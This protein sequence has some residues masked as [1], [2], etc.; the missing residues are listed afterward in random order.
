MNLNTTAKLGQNSVQGDYANLVK[1]FEEWRKFERPPIKDGA[2]D[3]TA[4]TRAARTEHARFL[5]ARLMAM[6]IK[7][8]T[9]KEQNN[10]AVQLP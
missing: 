2:P 7:N 3:Y 4:K 10:T 5:H 6:D 8:S 1:L 9:N